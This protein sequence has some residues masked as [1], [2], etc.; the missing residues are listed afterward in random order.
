MADS[1]GWRRDSRPRSSTTL[2][3]V[4]T[5]SSLRIGGRLPKGHREI[6]ARLL[7]DLGVHPG[8]RLL[9]CTCGI[10]TQ[11]LPLALRGYRV[12]GTDISAAAIARAQQ[13]AGKRDIPVDFAVCDVRNVGRLVPARFEAVFACDNSLAHLLTED[14]RLGALRSIRTCLV[15]GEV[16]LASLR[17]HDRLS[18]ERPSG[19]V[20]VTYTSEGRRRI[21][22]QAWQWS[23]TGGTILV[24]LFILKEN[25]DGWSCPLWTTCSRAWHRADMERA[26][27]AAGFDGGTWHSTDDSGYYQR[28]VTARATQSHRSLARRSLFRMARNRTI[29]DVWGHRPYVAS[30]RKRHRLP[31]A[32]IGCREETRA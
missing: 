30:G 4:S 16:F 25:Q 15:P 10:G 24:T 21:V 27:L 23:E 29:T 20:P 26:L 22:G 28:I 7:L 31:F 5:T 12:L 3:P 18:R 17:H 6:N 8:A 9:D 19:V 32:T 13:E 2:W 11:A 1:V 14:D